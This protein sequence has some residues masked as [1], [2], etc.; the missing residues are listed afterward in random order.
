MK[1]RRG[2][3]MKDDLPMRVLEEVEV[4]RDPGTPPIDPALL[5]DILKVEASYAF[6]TESDKP[7]RHIEGLIEAYLKAG[8]R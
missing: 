6:D 3:A 2:K 8:A 5:R 1:K 7:V 4:Q